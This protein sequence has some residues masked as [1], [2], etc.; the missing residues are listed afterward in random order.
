MI[1]RS[2]PVV[3]LT[4]TACFPYQRIS[5]G[6]IGCHPQDIEIRDARG[7]RFP[8]T[9]PRTWLAVC[10]GVDFRCV[11]NPEL[12]TG[13]GQCARVSTAPTPSAPPPALP[14]SY[15]KRVVQGDQG[16]VE[17]QVHFDARQNLMVAAAPRTRPEIDLALT[18]LE[19]RNVPCA[20]LSLTA[21]HSWRR[22]VPFRVLSSGPTWRIE[23]SAE[24]ALA[25]ELARP[26]P[27][28]TIEACGQT[29]TLAPSQLAVLARFAAVYQDLA[30]QPA[31]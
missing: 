20:K 27:T 24:P 21:N 13:S 9:G 12:T 3:A 11:A 28:L 16:G 31:H 26:E 23:A 22:D 10:H 30:A 19:K 5:S 29:L 18:V 8:G 15:V 25:T 17:A 14:Q 1:R 7:G 4:L 6:S 2:L